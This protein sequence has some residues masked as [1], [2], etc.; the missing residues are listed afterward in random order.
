MTLNSDDLGR[1]CDIALDAAKRSGALIQSYAG[2]EFSMNDKSSGSSAASQ[3]VTEVD[4]KSQALILD[5]ISPTL[6]DYDLGLLIEESD[7]DGSRFDK[8]YFWCIDP[9]DGTLPFVEQR[10]GYAVSIALVSREG[11]AVIG[12][13]YDPVTDSLYHA[14]QQQGAFRNQ[15][16]WSLEPPSDDLYTTVQ[17]GGAVINA[18]QV[19]EQAPACFVKNPK[20]EEGGGALWDYAATSCLFDEIGGYASD[21]RGRQLNL[22]SRESV[23]MNRHGVLFASHRFIADRLERD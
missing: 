12:V 3:I 5:V 4:L 16:P 21:R 6:V 8:H 1:L 22:N 20:A 14:V 13:V 11:R 2:R 19:L 7:D 10:P 23:F 18:V 17:D 15:Q 9:L